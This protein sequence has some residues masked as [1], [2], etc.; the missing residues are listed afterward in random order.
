MVGLSL[1]ESALGGQSAVDAMTAPK[2]ATGYFCPGCDAFC[3]DSET[4]REH[5]EPEEVQS[6]PGWL[7]GDRS[8]C[9][10]GIHRLESD[11]LECMRAGFPPDC[12][13]CGHLHRH[14]FGMS[15]TGA[16]CQSACD[17]RDFTYAT[18]EAT[19]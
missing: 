12:A 1:A 15:G 19:T 17:C 3:R 14:H 18:E 6:A 8:P 16:P 7:C 10:E 5:C 4:A 9:D 11:A 13:A 2:A